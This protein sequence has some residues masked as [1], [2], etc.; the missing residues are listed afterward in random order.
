[1]LVG[2]VLVVKLTE[3][4]GDLAGADLAGMDVVM[5]QDQPPPQLPGLQIQAVVAVVAAMA[6]T[7]L[8]AVLELSLF[9]TPTHIQMLP[10]QLVRQR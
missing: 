9:D 4:P 3:V 2:A 5:E 7:R 10:L 8:L 1:M 6:H